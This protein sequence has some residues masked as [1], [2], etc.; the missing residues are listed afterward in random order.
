MTQSILKSI[1]IIGLA[2]AIS[3]LTIVGIVST[4]PPWGSFVPFTGVEALPGL[5]IIIPLLYMNFK[6]TSFIVNNRIVSKR[7]KFCCL[8]FLAVG[9]LTIARY[10]IYNT[11]ISNPEGNFN[12][13]RRERTAIVEKIQ[14]GTLHGEKR[15]TTPSPYNCTEFI[16]LPDSYSDLARDG[17]VKVTRRDDILYIYF[18]YDTTNFGDILH[19]FVYTSDPNYELGY[20]SDARSR[21]YRERLAPNWYGVSEDQ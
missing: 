5:F 6:G 9:W 7:I 3:G 12:L 1:E 15:C 16:R 10:W 13:S 14:N 20:L 4:S 19:Y 21:D 11:I 17:R 18:L 8:L 2:I